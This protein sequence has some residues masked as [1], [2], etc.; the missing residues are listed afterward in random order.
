MTISDFNELVVVV[1]VI[2]VGVCMCVCVCFL[3]FFF[4]FFPF[5]RGG[6]PITFK[7]LGEILHGN[8]LVTWNIP[9]LMSN[10]VRI[11]EHIYIKQ[12]SCH[13]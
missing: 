5:F 9:T 12:L 2:V 3:L 8:F 7:M 13:E 4:F 10:V 6:R 11:R 1:V